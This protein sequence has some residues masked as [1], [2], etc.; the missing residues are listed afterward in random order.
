[1]H[2]A[3]I[4]IFLDFQL[5]QQY[6]GLWILHFFG[7]EGVALG[8]F[9]RCR[10]RVPWR[11]LSR[12]L[13]CCYLCTL[14]LSVSGVS[15]NQGHQIWTP[16]NGILHIRASKRTPHLWK[17]AY[18]CGRHWGGLPPHPMSIRRGAL[19]W[20]AARLGHGIRMEHCKPVQVSCICIM[21]AVF[22]ITSFASLTF[23]ALPEKDPLHGTVLSKTMQTARTN[24]VDDRTRASP[25]NQMIP[26]GFV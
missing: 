22:D 9:W 17:V 11:N 15:K 20:G 6:S 1:M 7:I 24:T 10:G 18:L 25:N 5:T 12:R 21:W 3:D 14:L 4:G 13:A 23:T 16:R 19:V 2:S 26:G 8:T